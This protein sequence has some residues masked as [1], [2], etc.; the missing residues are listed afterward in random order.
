MPATWRGKAAGG[1]AALAAVEAP[2]GGG[3]TAA[4]GAAGWLP[5]GRAGSPAR[6][7]AFV[8]GF[9]DAA[10]PDRT[11]AVDTRRVGAC[12]AFPWGFVP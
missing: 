1:P 10:V 5:G 9:S 7:V 8:F 2:S 12:A 4:P 11:V 6:T 3:G